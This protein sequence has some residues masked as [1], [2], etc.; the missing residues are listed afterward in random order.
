M[1]LYV[2]MRLLESAPRRY[3][4]GI[5]LLTMG[6]LARS[7]DRLVA[8]IPDSSCVLDLGCGTGFLT[9]RAVRRGA[10]VKGI[11]INP[12]MLEIAQQQAQKAGVAEH[13]DFVEMGV[14]ELDNEKPESYDV[15]TS[16]L[17]FSELTED[18]LSYTLGQI[19]RILKPGGLLLVADEVRPVSL[20]GRFIHALLKVP[21]AAV[22]YLLTRQTTHAIVQLPEKLM[23][24]GLP[25][26]SIQYNRMGSFIEAVASKP[27]GKAI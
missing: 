5:S 24:A 13:I 18:E 2:L 11:D 12:Q 3:E 14:A 20:I 26:K 22:T 23:G 7:Y 6:R 9:I 8:H 21:L 15:V 1:S 17:C 19:Q 4:L 16:G 10:R 25:I 27:K